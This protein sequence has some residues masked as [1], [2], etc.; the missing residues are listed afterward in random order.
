MKYFASALEFRQYSNNLI[1]SAHSSV[2]H[3]LKSQRINNQRRYHYKHGENYLY[4]VHY[5]S[6]K[7]KRHNNLDNKMKE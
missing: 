7:Y 1:F 6:S 4:K 5:T 2:T 3:F